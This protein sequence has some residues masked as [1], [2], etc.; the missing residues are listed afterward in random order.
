MSVAEID[1]YTGNDGEVKV[2]CN[3]PRWYLVMLA[4]SS[5]G[6]VEMALRT[7]LRTTP[8][9]NSHPDR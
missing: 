7:A 2:T 3:S 1:W 6:R 4:M 5:H 8:S 9:I